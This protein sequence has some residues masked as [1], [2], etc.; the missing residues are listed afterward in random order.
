VLNI[1]N[2]KKKIPKNPAKKKENRVP[3]VD[4]EGKEDCQP[5]DPHVEVEEGE[6]HIENRFYL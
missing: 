5:G 3:P 1:V 2:K 6:E 4:C